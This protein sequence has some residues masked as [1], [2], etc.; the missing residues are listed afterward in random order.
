MKKSQQEQDR[1]VVAEQVRYVLLQTMHP[2]R[3]PTLRCAPGPPVQLQAHEG[4]PI[5]GQH[6]AQRVD[7]RQ[8]VNELG[9]PR[10][11]DVR[12]AQIEG[13][14]PRPQQLL[15]Q[16]ARDRGLRSRHPA[17]HLP[18]AGRPRRKLPG[19]SIVVVLLLLLHAVAAAAAA[20]PLL[21]L[22]ALLLVRGRR[23]GGRGS[24]G[25]SRRGPTWQNCRS[26][27]RLLL[28]LG[29]RCTRPAGGMREV[30][31]VPGNRGL[32][33]CATSLRRLKALSSRLALLLELRRDRRRH[34]GHDTTHLGRGLRRRRR[35]RARR[36][37]LFLV[38]LP[39]LVL[40]LLAFIPEAVLGVQLLDSRLLPDAGRDLRAD[41][42]RHVHDGAAPRA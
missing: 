42:L 28:L 4:G 30:P 19:G 31:E 39:L 38:D 32:L 9:K 2:R 26:L 20:L 14:C 3:L 33:G 36:K 1:H 6:Q 18:S 5:H 7:P 41:A 25:G 10:L 27:V 40:V 24:R 34:L 15:Q 13:P 35:R 12:G 21:R 16:G 17:G 23:R 11:R 8:P 37:D 22:A 29:R